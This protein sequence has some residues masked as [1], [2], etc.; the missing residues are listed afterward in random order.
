MN[1]WP[2]NHE[3]KLTFFFSF[4][5]KS[6]WSILRYDSKINIMPPPLKTYKI[7]TGHCPVIAGLHMIGF[8]QILKH[9]LI[10]T[11]NNSFLF[12]WKG[13][14]FGSTTMTDSPGRASPFSSPFYPG[15]TTFGGS[16]AQRPAKRPRTSPYE[17]RWSKAIHLVTNLIITNCTFIN[18]IIAST[19]FG[20]GTIRN[21]GVWSLRKTQ[22][23]DNGPL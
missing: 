2:L 7:L 20:S 10:L 14:S 17:V 9:C 18:L 11:F 8:V 16:S 13:S 4:C 1:F 19:S 22:I 5:L 15:K 12:L 23:H 3:S 21:N 6:P